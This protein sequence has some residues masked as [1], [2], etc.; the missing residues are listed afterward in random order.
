MERPPAHWPAAPRRDVA[1][2]IHQGGVR[3]APRRRGV[4][5]SR[6]R[7]EAESS[8]A[9]ARD[10]ARWRSVS[11]AGSRRVGRWLPKVSACSSSACDVYAPT[12]AQSRGSYRRNTGST[13][14]PISP[15]ARHRALS[16]HALLRC[17]RAPRATAA[18]L[19]TLRGHARSLPGTDYGPCRQPR[20]L[21]RNARAKR[22][23]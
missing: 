11:P 21:D 22:N 13:S 15:D 12:S 2:P 6:C 18:L 10:A 9:R 1:Q 7:S 3:H 16:V 17:P 8:R 23:A 20:Y 5:I 19:P 4:R 14:A